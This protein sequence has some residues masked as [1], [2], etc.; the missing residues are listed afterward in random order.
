VQTAQDRLRSLAHGIQRCRRCALHRTRTHAVPGEGP[1]DARVFFIGEAPGRREDEAARPFVGAA[2]E[3]L[4]ARLTALGLA[5]DT[6][7]ITSCVKCRP[8]NN[9]NPR[10]GE[11][12][13]CR[14]RWLRP[15]LELVSPRLIVLLGT[16]A[17][18]AF[19]ERAPTLKDLHGRVR[20]FDG[21]RWF[22]TYHPAAAMRFPRIDRAVREDF[23]TLK[24]VL[25]DLHG[26]AD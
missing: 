3:Y 8:P 15:Q 5:R 10:A 20:E 1:V 26:D 22:V 9:R 19:I 16:T 2:G 4:N 23:R 11:V 21:R 18:A 17:A 24:R 14:D 6:A 12:A 25:A 7:F 13:T